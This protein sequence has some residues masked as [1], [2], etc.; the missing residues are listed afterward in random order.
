MSRLF[1]EGSIATCALVLLSAGVVVRA[2][3]DV[4]APP[5]ANPGPTTSR[6]E[7]P[8]LPTLK[9]EWEFL[10]L[11]CREIGLAAA[12][13]NLPARFLAKLIWQE[14][15]FDP[16]AVSRAGAQGIAQFMPG[17]AR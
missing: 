8:A 4:Q 9:R 3:P 13:H 1:R 5:K 6:V 17:T 10:S 12:A 14:S 2:E 7:G 11:I 15:R 16:R